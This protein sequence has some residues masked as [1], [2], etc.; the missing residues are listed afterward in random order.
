MIN[1]LDNFGIAYL[2]FIQVGFI[3]G[4]IVR[5]FLFVEYSIIFIP[6]GDIISVRA[7]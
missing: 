5:F 2:P 6:G 7:K 4:I 1:T 3:S